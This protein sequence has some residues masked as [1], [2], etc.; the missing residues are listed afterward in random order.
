MRKFY[1]LPLLSLTSVLFAMGEGRSVPAE[2]RK[3]S[4]VVKDAKGVTHDIEGLVCGEGEIRFKKG[5]VDY[6]ISQSVI[7]SIKVL[8][9]SGGYVA[10]K[11]TF[12][13]GETE[14]FNVSTSL[15]CEAQTEKGIIDFY[16]NDV[17]EIKF[18]KGEGK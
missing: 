15:R 8:G 13:D 9:K 6:R 18:V 16:I 5:A 12:D 17:K 1:I 10:V 2:F 3:M 4:A 7:S 11:V 14:G